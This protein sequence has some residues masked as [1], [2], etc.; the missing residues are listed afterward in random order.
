M[1]APTA[2]AAAMVLSSIGNTSSDQRRYPGGFTACTMT[3]QPEAA[4]MTSARFMA[5]PRIQL[6]P[7]RRS[8]W[9]RADIP[10]SVPQLA[11]HLTTDTTGCTEDQDCTF[12]DHRISPLG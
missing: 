10:A 11:R 3:E 4:A 7:F 2:H 9:Q 8:S 5:S 1:V 12:A 6:M